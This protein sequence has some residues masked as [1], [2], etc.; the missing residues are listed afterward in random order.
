MDPLGSVPPRKILFAFTTHKITDP[1]IHGGPYITCSW[2]FL[3]IERA[4]QLYSL[5]IVFV[6]HYHNPVM[7]MQIKL[8]KHGPLKV[9]SEWSW[10]HKV[11]NQEFENSKTFLFNICEFLKV[12]I[13]I[14]RRISILTT[15]LYRGGEMSWQGQFIKNR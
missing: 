7:T 12:E 13:A 4:T 11:I 15:W 2:I 8:E 14:Y 5:C 6:Q 1:C 9:A 10:Y 3:N